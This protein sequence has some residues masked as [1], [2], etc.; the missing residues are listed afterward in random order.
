MTILHSSESNEWYT[1]AKY[2]DAAREVMGWIDLDPCGTSLSNETVKAKA[3]YTEQ[4]DG[5][6]FE[7]YGRVWLN[8]PYGGQTSRWVKKLLDEYDAGRV[9]E[10]ILLVGS[11]TDRKWFKRLWDFPI[12]F[13]DHRIRFLKMGTY[14]GNSP[15]H[16]SA[17]VYLGKSEHGAGKNLKFNRIFSGFGPVARAARWY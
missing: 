5:L 1:P 4:D 13:T 16:G 14:E 17:I 3:I 8:P 2:V 12:C 10:A 15:T 9:K 7:W 6:S 11:V